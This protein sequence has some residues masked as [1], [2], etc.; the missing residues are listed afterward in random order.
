MIKAIA[1]AFLAISAV[2]FLIWFTVP[3]FYGV[4][5][6]GNYFGIFLSLCLLFR[7][8]FEKAYICIKERFLR[9]N[10]LKILLRAVQISAFAFIAYAAVVSCLMIYAMSAE[11]DKESTALVLGAEVKPWGPSVLLRQR[12]DAADRY[13]R[14]TPEASAVVTGGKGSNEVISEGQ[15]MFDELVKYGISP[16]RVLIEDKA[17][18]TYQNIRYSMRI[19]QENNLNPNLAVVTDSYHQ[20]RSRIIAKKAN[21]NIKIG[22]VNT[23]NNLLG[24]SAYP[25]FFVREWIAIP[26]ELIK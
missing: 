18:N 20:L 10:L 24:L 3:M 7:F 14:E 9:N 15:C 5:N 26:V 1:K 11:P 19:I 21:H 2:V 23:K 22:A 6:V 12:I 4:K 16:D 17:E 8:G 13:L 25:S